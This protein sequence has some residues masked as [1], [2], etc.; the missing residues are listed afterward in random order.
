MRW[1]GPYWEP[2][3]LWFGIYWHSTRERAM[4]AVT[5]VCVTNVY[6]CLVP[7]FPI[8]LTWTRTYSVT[9]IPVDYEA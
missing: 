8:R 7:C 2:R 3:D 4:G 9:L 5:G 6:V 1:K